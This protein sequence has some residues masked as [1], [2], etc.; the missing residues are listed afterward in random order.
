[1]GEVYRARDTKLNRDVAIK[2]LL[3]AV[4]NDPDRLA[5][6][7]REAQVLASLNHPNI[8][9]I[10]GLEE[11]D[12]VTALILELVEGDD[13]AQR[14]ARGPIPLDEALPIARQIAEAL[15]A[16]HEHGII[17]RDLKPANIKVRPDGTVKVLDFGLAKAM[18]P[19]GGL[20]ASAMSAA[21]LTSPA[22]MTGAGMVLGTA[23]YM[24][25]EQ[26][27]GKAVDR[28]SDIWALG[29]VMFEML[30]GTRAFP[31]DDVADTIVSVMSKEPDW[32]E[33]PPTVS[34]GIRRLLRQ[35]L[36][37]DPKRRLDSAAAVRIALDEA[38]PSGGDAGSVSPEP[39]VT[40]RRRGWRHTVAWSTTAAVLAAAAVVIVWAPW[41]AAPAPRITRTTI[42]TTGAAALTINGSDR[43]LALSPDGSHVIYVGNNGTQLFVRALDALEPTLL[44]TGGDGLRAPFVSPDGQWVGFVSSNTLRKVAIT[45]GPPITITSLDSSSRGATWAGD[46]TIIFA[47]GSGT[48]LWR[49]LAAGGTPE[50]MTRPDR[51]KGEGNYLWPEVL[52]GGDALLFTITSKGGP[53]AAQVVVRDLRSGMQKV[54][55]RGGS[56]A[57][58]APSGHLVY[59]ARGSL[60]AI[61]FDPSQLETR[62]TAVLVLPRLVA[63]SSGGADF[64]VAADGT[65]LYADAPGSLAPDARTLVWVDRAGNE[66]PIGAPPAAYEHPRLSPDGTRILLSSAGDLSIWDVRRATLTRLTID[67]DHGSFPVWLPDGRRVAFSAG[68]IWWRAADGTGAAERLTT[69]KD[70]QFVTGTTPDGAAITFHEITPA[71]GRDLGQ[72]AV[73]A[74][75]RVTPLLQ[76]NF[77]E[78]NGVVSPDGRWL[79]YDSNS[80]G[81]FEI[82][83]RPFPRVG[84]GQW[85]VSTSGGARPLWARSGKELFFAGADGALLSVPVEAS[86]ATWHAATPRRILEGRYY[87]GGGTI[88]RT[89]DVSLD[90]ER[91]LMIKAPGT[92]RGAAP[93]ALILVQHWDEEL[94]RLVPAG[95]R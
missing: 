81:S 76:T 79:A 28:R 16:A 31:G 8:A 95:R 29:A 44:V 35:C 75:R 80:S 9:H 13:L 66:E 60:W 50:I 42:T 5:R 68:N 27:R 12:G 4:A 59:V 82:Y 85:Q 41:R 70:A 63:T 34:T 62:G 37:K 14:I 7:S 39:R 17:H 26:A 47:T 56:H 2:V 21:T 94:K 22:L 91:F 51:A 19:A 38:S 86:G 20:R 74:T 15:E 40:S 88:S 49:V 53:D 43:D 87:T 73:D 23:A 33:L 55:V 10:H 36:E 69:S 54:L 78:R 3:P 57:H 84:G 52:P 30:T 67:P 25:P 64:A 18:D 11:T 45:G 83:V 46:D 1:M 24:S 58:Y 6:F 48:G 71:M 90:G 65:L 89:Y 93:P 72:V 32:N 92:D 61:A 77:D